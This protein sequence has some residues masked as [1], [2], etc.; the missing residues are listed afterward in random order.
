MPLSDTVTAPERASSTAERYRWRGVQAAG[1]PSR[2]TAPSR[3]AAF[4]LVA[5]VLFLLFIGAAAPTPLYGIYRAQLRFSA[6]TLTA[7]FAIYAL[8]LLLTLLVFGSVSDYLGRRHVILAALMVSAGAYAVFLAAHSVGLLFAARA[9]QGLAV[10]TALGALGAALIDLQPAGRGLAP[11]VTA[12]APALGLGAGALGASA[13]AQYG[14]APARLVWWL[15]LGA[16]VAAG[17]GILA[18]PEPGTWRAGVLTSLRPRVGV[19]RQVRGTFAT[20][21]P[22]LIAVWA[23]S[24]LYQSLGPS[25]AAQVTGSRDLLWGGLLN[26][27]LTGVAA[28]TTVAF[29]G[30]TPRTAMLAGC[31]VLL[32]G[33]AMTFAAIATATAAA[34]L[35]GTAIAGIGFGLALLGANRILIALAAPGQRAGLVAAIFIVN[36][37][38]LSIPALIAGVATT[39]FGLHRT[40]LAYCVATAALVAVAAGS[41]MLRR[42]AQEMN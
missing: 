25:L 22:C 21:V 17:A 15:L 34:F 33:L 9:L 31:L 30:L 26:F 5:G 23:L 3:A 10:G 8:V 41:L 13:L 6:S 38:G 12:A 24:G 28:A 4:W 1:E 42:R 39:H 27:L 37:L 32:A 40:A 7:V 2:R 14:P 16:S 19:P 18:M 36:F 29:R 35:A 11:L 20:A